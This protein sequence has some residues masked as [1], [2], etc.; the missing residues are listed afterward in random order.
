M[1]IVELLEARLAEDETES[2]DAIRDE[3]YPESWANVL[4][5]RVL[6]FIERERIFVDG[7]FR[8]DREERGSALIKPRC[9]V[10]RPGNLKPVCNTSPA[11]V[12]Q[13][14]FAQGPVR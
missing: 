13:A 12:R 7:N 9:P 5:T 10:P 8:I 2:R 6:V 1:E 14:G 11:T 3:P 4:A